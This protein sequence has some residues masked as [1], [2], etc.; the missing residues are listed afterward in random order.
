MEMK[1]SLK[2]RYF[3]MNKLNLKRFIFLETVAFI[4]K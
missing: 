2:D 1:K 3:K 4:K